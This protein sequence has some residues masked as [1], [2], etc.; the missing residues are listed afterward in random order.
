MCIQEGCRRDTRCRMRN[1][2]KLVGLVGHRWG[3]CREGGRF[4]LPRGSE[5]SLPLS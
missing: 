4:P 5:L 2:E 3:S 1:R